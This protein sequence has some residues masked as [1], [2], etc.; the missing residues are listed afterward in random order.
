MLLT[1][2]IA[3]LV[4]GLIGVAIGVAI[5]SRQR[6][7]QSVTAQDDVARSEHASTHPDDPAMTDV[8]APFLDDIGSTLRAAVDQLGLG[9]VVGDADGRIVYRNVAAT[10]MHGTHAG[11]IIEEHV[12]QVL[13][14][15][16][17]GQ[18]LDDEVV[19]HGPPRLTFQLIAE[20]MPNGYSVATIEDISERRRTDAMRTDFVANISH[21]LKTPV[22]AIA[23]LAEALAGELDQTVI[24]RVAGRMVDE[25]HRAV[26]A[27]DDLL[28]LSRIE[29]AP[30]LDEDVD[31]AGIVS[32]AIVRGRVVDESK[33][34]TVTAVDSGQ[35]IVV[36]GDGRQLV[37]AI[38]NLVENA[39]KYSGHGGVV[40]VR[41]RRD[42]RSVE[43]MVADQGDGIPARDLDRIFERFYRVD[44]ARSRETGGTGLG[45]AIVRHVA[46]N[47]GG[48]VLVSSTEG[49][50]STFVLRLPAS[51]LV[52]LPDDDA[53]EVQD[54][55]IHQ[56]EG[57]QQ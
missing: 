50:G 29:S 48:E 23:V 10:A 11:V 38:G 39:V 49:D 53:D 7:Q 55:T 3:L 21:E 41:T 5:G 25:A 26:D 18:H 35:T 54:Q 1:T 42:D 6:H 36:R 17:S 16:R 56:T 43:V 51:L 34:V 15:G 57:R 52:E 8:T 2:L 22:G 40:Q 9:V 45:L 33:N 44:R 27:I 4:G 37:S 14:V 31:L 47:H 46:S 13:A 12:E 30:R 19:L 24:D 28:E 32:A 20:P